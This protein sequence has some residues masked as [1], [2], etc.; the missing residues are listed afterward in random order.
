VRQI[1]EAVSSI[2]R[3]R[4]EQRKNG[5]KTN[6]RRLYVVDRK[7]LRIKTIEVINSEKKKIVISSRL[8]IN[9]EVRI[10]IEII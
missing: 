9:Y 5:K 10:E 1:G 8:E 7:M 4:W 3:G 6:E 2:S